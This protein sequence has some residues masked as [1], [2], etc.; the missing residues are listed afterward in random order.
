[1]GRKTFNVADTITS[2]NEMLSASTCDANVRQGMIHIAE[3][4]LH[5]SGNYNGF[6]YLTKDKIEAAKTDPT[7]VPGIIWVTTEKGEHPEFAN[8]DETRRRY[9]L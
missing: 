1:M 8:T 7:V 6:Q 2:I 4:I 3:E 5:K 9:F